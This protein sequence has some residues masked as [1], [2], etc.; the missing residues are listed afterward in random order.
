MEEL[1]EDVRILKMLR[2]EIKSKNENEEVKI[3]TRIVKVFF[4]GQTIP[5]H[6]TYAYT[7]IKVSPFVAL[8]QCYKCYRFNHFAQHCK[9]T[10][11]RCK[12]CFQ[13]YAVKEAC[14][15][16]ICVNCNFEHAP[17]AKECPARVKTY[18]I[19]RTMTLEE[20]SYREAHRKVA[21]ILGNRFELLDNYDNNFPELHS[22][23]T[24]NMHQNNKSTS[25]IRKILPFTKV[26]K[27]NIN[28]TNKNRRREQANARN[29]MQEWRETIKP[30]KSN[31]IIQSTRKLQETRNTVNYYLKA[32]KAS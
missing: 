4:K 10:R 20:S 2:V 1:M 16:L 31:E 11:S 12:K 3:P 30:I 26:I 23:R 17:T 19:K 27:S 14:Q 7:K 18:I 25:Y 8:T 24:N 29:T 15:K 5:E 32:L 6:I 13:I 22:K 21:G 28:N 9:K